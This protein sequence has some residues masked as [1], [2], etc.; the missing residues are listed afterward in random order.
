MGGA[1]G[2]GSGNSCRLHR[3][4][5]E[6]QPVIRRKLPRMAIAIDLQRA[7]VVARQEQAVPRRRPELDG[8]QTV[9]IG[10]PGTGQEGIAV[11]R[12]RTVAADATDR[13]RPEIVAADKGPLNG[14]ARM[15]RIAVP[16]GNGA[17]VTDTAD[18]TVADTGSGRSARA[19]RI[20]LEG[21]LDDL[22]I[23]VDQADACRIVHAN[24]GRARKRHEPGSGVGCI[25]LNALQHHVV[26]DMRRIRL[27]VAVK[28][29][30]SPVLRRE[31][32]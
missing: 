30:G 9:R 29:D 27:R 16:V 20:F 11:L 22:D 10:D 25:H 1:T 3:P 2:D 17:I 12:P 15:Q 26:A 28:Q 32:D 5:V 31:L 21:R 18:V 13:N 24:A 14:R 23:A 4:E 6:F 7:F 19:L 8:R